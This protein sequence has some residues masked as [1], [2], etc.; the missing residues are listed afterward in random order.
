MVLNVNS[1]IKYD[2]RE[3]RVILTGKNNNA[4]QVSVGATYTFDAEKLLY[5]NLTTRGRAIK[6][7][8]KHAN[9]WKSY[10]DYIPTLQDTVK[11]DTT[12]MR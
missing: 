10:M 2:V 7:N 9:A 3:Q 6:R 11:K 8:R 4:I 5:E 12:L 1:A